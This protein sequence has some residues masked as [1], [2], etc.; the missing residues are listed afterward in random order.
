M[1]ITRY[2]TTIIGLKRREDTHNIKGSNMVQLP[3][4]G[5]PA[6]SALLKTFLAPKKTPHWLLLNDLI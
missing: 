6:L 5:F 2:S 3:L 1:K 4:P